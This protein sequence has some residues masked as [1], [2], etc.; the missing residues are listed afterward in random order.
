MYIV[1]V[2]PSGKCRKGTAMTPGMK[3]LREM[4][5]RVAAES[6]TREALIRELKSCN[7]SQ[8]DVTCGSMHIHA[9][10]T[11]YSQELTVFLGYNN[12]A[13]MADLTD[14]FDCRDSW[15]YRTKNQGTDEI[16][17]VWVNL[18]GAT[19]PELL[20][21]TL[22]QDAI[23]GGLTSRM[24]FV[25]ESNKAK[26]VPVPILSR[27]EREIQDKLISDLNRICMMTGDFTV[28]DAFI[29]RYTDWYM[30]YSSGPPLFEDYRFAGYLERRPTHLLKLCMITCASRSDTMII[31]KVDFDRALGILELTE[32][33]MPYTF[34][35]VGRAS[36]AEVMQRVMS[37][38]RMAK[39]ISLGDL[40]S[41]FYQDIDKMTLEKMVESLKIMGFADTVREGDKWIIKYIDKQKLM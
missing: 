41:R 22:P 14:W 25:Y 1:L 39:V 30:R 4:G 9:S 36:T 8:V 15:T 10:L 28:T 6:I 16:I 17:G 24:I 18:F 26:V 21:T 2:G 3:M 7:D 35:G 38:I 27:E 34:S 32:K 13:L 40:L 11:I 29:E 20:Q 5:I 19:T 33:K 12:Q 31:D 37:T 23:G